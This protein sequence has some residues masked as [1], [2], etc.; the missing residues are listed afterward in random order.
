MRKTLLYLHLWAGLTAAFFLLLLGVTGT[1]M[2]FE[3]EIDRALNAKL[4][5]VEPAGRPLTLDAITQKIQS[6]YPGAKIEGFELPQRPDLSLFVGFIDSGGKEVRLFL[7]PY[8]GEPLGAPEQGNHLMSRIHQFHTHLLAGNAGKQIVGW[9][10]VLLLLLSVSGIILWWPRKLFRLRWSGSG[11]RFN[12][13]L[14]N[15]VGI[16]SSV[17]LLVFAWTAICI[18]W[19]REV[20]NL[21]Q[22]MSHATPPRA[23]PAQPPQPGAAQLSPDRLVQI[24]QQTA[25]GAAV[26]AL[27]FPGNPRQPASLALKYP[28]DHTPL[29]RTRMRLDAYTGRVLMVQS[30]R[31]MSAPLKYARLWNREIHTGDILGWP[32]RILAA[33]FSLMLPVLT[34]SGP[35]IWWNRRQPAA[36]P[37]SVNPTGGKGKHDTDFKAMTDVR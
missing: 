25:P 28:E 31:E 30:S 15:S 1:L 23:K 9:S 3:N 24:A 8:T 16:L 4:A 12:F 17:F 35:I 18:H 13:E 11:K 34:L 7:N 2:V 27:D 37:R 29:G 36:K 19:E 26:V 21:A 33:F 22:Q 20:G 5:Y 10:G 14:H 32:T 6:R